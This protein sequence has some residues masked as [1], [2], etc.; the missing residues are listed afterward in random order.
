MFCFV[1]E[2]LYWFS[3]KYHATCRKAVLSALKLLLVMFRG[4]KFHKM[5]AAQPLD[6][7]CRLAAFT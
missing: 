3:G 2:L 7:H 1:N 5:L 6:C 4:K